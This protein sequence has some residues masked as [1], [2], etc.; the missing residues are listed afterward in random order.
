M[1]KKVSLVERYAIEKVKAKRLAVKMTPGQ[2][3]RRLGID[4]Y[5][6]AHVESDNYMDKYNLNHL[7]AIA[8]ILHCSIKEFIPRSPLVDENTKYIFR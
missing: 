8:I 1:K 5:F 7:N 4:S 3:S 6:V 2:L